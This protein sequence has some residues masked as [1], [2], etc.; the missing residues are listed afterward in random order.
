M[1]RTADQLTATSERAGEAIRSLYRLG[2]LYAAG[3]RAATTPPTVVIAL[4]AAPTAKFLTVMVTLLVVTGWSVIYVLGL[5]RGPARWYTIVDASVLISLCVGTP[6]LVPVEWLV[7]GHSWIMAFTS[8]ACVAYQCHTEWVLGLTTTLGVIGALAAGSYLSTPDGSPIDILITTTWSAVGALLCRLLW[9]LVRHGG[10]I[11][12]RA[13]A[14][15]EEAR[16][17]QR[18]A[19]AVRADESALANALHD[20]AAT[21]LLMVGVGRIPRDEDLLAAQAERDLA[22]L[23]T[24]GDKM[25]ARSDLTLLLRAAVNLVPIEVTFDVT[26][27]VNLPAQV[28]AAIADAAGEVLNNVVKHAMVDSV[29]VHVRGNDHS[30][31]VSIVDKGCGFDPRRVSE[32]RRGIRESVHGRMARIG[33]RTQV[34]SAVGTGTAVRLEWVDA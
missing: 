22:V 34:T 16:T 10:V 7:A 2:R 8:F 18:V 31:E 23:R 13:M 30:A 32:T 1:A 14:D 3:I 17:R 11:A 4:F 29:L 9:I 12:D 25:P 5:L 21:T 19:I 6:W 33:G 26:G 15:A 28:A 20:T 27:P 24:Y